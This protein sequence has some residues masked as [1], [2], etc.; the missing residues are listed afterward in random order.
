MAFTLKYLQC[1]T[2]SFQ[3]VF[4]FSFKYNAEC[5]N[6]K[7]VYGSLK[8]LTISTR[9]W[10]TADQGAIFGGKWAKN[11]FYT[12]HIIFKFKYFKYVVL[13]SPHLLVSHKKSAVVLF[14]AFLYVIVFF[15]FF[16]LVALRVFFL[17]SDFEQFDLTKMWLGL[18]FFKFVFGVG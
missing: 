2:I 7:I 11:G 18:V 13:L 16:N 1:D 4:L 3:I 17:T 6:R 12:C 9:D 14:F 8:K 10:Q 5:V 15:F